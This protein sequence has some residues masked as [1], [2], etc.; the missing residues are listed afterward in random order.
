MV[1]L[2]GERAKKGVEGG[3]AANDYSA[4]GLVTIS[5]FW[6]VTWK[7]NYRGEAHVRTQGR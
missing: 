1:M 3:E 5:F 4:I 7:R 2:S 6:N